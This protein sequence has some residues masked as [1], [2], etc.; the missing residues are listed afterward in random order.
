MLNSKL[1]FVTRTEAGSDIM[2]TDL[3]AK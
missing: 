2:E 1:G 3:P